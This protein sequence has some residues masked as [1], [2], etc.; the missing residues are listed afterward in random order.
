MQEVPKGGYPA[1]APEVTQALLAFNVGFTSVVNGLQAAWRGGDNL[2]LNDAIATMFDL[3]QLASPLY[4]MTVPGTE[5]TYG[6]TF[7]YRGSGS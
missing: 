5:E 2:A 1:Q 6:P 3:Q 7:E 4:E